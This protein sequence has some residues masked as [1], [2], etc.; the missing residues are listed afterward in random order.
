[1]RKTKG[2]AVY[3]GGNDLSGMTAGSDSDNKI[4][5]IIEKASDFVRR[6]S[7]QNLRVIFFRPLKRRDVFD[8]I[9][10]SFVERLELAGHV[11]VELEA[12]LEDDDFVDGI[13]YKKS[14]VE[15]KIRPKL[16]DQI[17]NFFS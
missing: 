3:L 14:T 10:E 5:D 6:C 9:L 13:H 1:M 15:S 16:I 7:D 12:N 17:K 11:C 2:I 8:G 4:D